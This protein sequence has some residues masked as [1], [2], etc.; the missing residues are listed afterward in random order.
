MIFTHRG[1]AGDVVY[2]LQGVKHLCDEADEQC[3]FYLSPCPNTR[4]LMTPEHAE[5]LLPLLRAQPYIACAAWHP[6]GLGI[7][8]DV[9]H[10]KFGRHNL[11]ISDQ[12]NNWLDLPMSGGGG[13][14]LTITEPNPVAAVVFARS[15]RYRSARFPWKQAYARFGAQACF[16]GTDDEYREFTQTFG[17]LPY[18]VTPT[19]LDVARVIAGCRL[20]IGNQSCPRAIAEGLKVPV[21]MEVCRGTCDNCRFERRDA[22]YDRLPP[23][24]FGDLP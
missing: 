16:V 21:C 9:G 3:T 4:E 20:F 2:Q 24:G 18:A 12:L 17:P 23:P 10:R 6:S 22:W 7:R 13:P 14:W 19:L 5:N 1:D 8:I 15:P 11:N